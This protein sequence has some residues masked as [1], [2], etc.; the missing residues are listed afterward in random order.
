M[1]DLHFIPNHWTLQCSD[2]YKTNRIQTLLQLLFENVRSCFWWREANQR[3]AWV[4]CWPYL[5]EREKSPTFFLLGRAR[6]LPWMP[7]DLSSASASRPVTPLWNH[8]GARTTHLHPQQISNP[9][10]HKYTPWIICSYKYNWIMYNIYKLMH[11][12]ARLLLTA[13]TKWF[14]P[15]QS[16]RKETFCTF[17]FNTDLGQCLS[18]TRAWA[19]DLPSLVCCALAHQ[20]SRP[21]IP[22]MWHLRMCYE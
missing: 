14:W 21:I 13:W 18:C 22:V 12:A 10:S 6:K 4:W 5:T 2:F 15:C 8:L 9:W 19:V 11:K 7:R 3:S 20:E 16:Y 17:N 1:I